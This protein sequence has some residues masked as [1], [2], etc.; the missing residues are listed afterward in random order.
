MAPGNQRSVPV[1]A[2]VVK[3]FFAYSVRGAQ[4][5]RCLFRRVAGRDY[6]LRVCLQPA[7]ILLQRFG[8]DLKNLGAQEHTHAADNDAVLL[9]LLVRDGSE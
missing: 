7:F 2:A 5:R 4:N 8:I 9:A 3:C 6:F 1:H